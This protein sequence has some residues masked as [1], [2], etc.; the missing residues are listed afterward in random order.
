MKKNLWSVAMLTLLTGLFG[1]SVRAADITSA[2]EYPHP[3]LSAV[4]GEKTLETIAKQQ[5]D[6]TDRQQ[7]KELVDR[8]SVL[9]DEK[10]GLSQAQLFTNDAQ[11]DNYM[12]GRHTGHLQGNKNIAKVYDEFLKKQDVVYHLN[13]QQVV[14]LNGDDTADGISYC[15]VV[16]IETVNGNRVKRTQGVRYEDKYKKVKGQW[17]IRSRKAFFEWVNYEPFNAKPM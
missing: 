6:L 4:A 11:V 8:F 7:I 12:E 5:S 1:L 17:L 15:Y 3:K 13:G 16:L 14:R 10:D 9:A 2:T